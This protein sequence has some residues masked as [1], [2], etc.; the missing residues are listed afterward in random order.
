VCV[1]IAARAHTHTH[2][3][4]HTQ[5]IYGASAVVVVHDIETNRQHCF[6][7]NDGALVAALA[8]HP[9]HETVT[10]THIYMYMY[11]YITHTHT[12]ARTRA[13][14]HRAWRRRAHDPDAEPVTKC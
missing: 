7:A 14:T 2:T 1:R 13:H 6:G 5:V 12:H 9:D 10:C 11:A 3:H 4:T 8:L